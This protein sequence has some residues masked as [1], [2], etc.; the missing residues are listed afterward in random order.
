MMYVWDLMLH[1]ALGVDLALLVSFYRL[2]RNVNVIETSKLFETSVISPTR[3][4]Y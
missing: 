3:C 2:L 4:F 1:P